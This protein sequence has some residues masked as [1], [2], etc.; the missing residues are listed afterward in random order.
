MRKVSHLAPA[1]FFTIWLAGVGS[2]WA[3]P[4]GDSAWVRTTLAAPSFVRGLLIQDAGKLYAWVYAADHFKLHSSSDNGVNWTA[5]GPSLSADHDATGL[6][7]RGS[8]FFLAARLGGVL[9][10]AEGDTAWVPVNSGFPADKDVYSI[11]VSGGVL[12]AGTNHSIF[13]SRDN[14]AKWFPISEGIPD[15]TIIPN[16]CVVGTTLFLATNRGDSFRGTPKDSGYAW[17]KEIMRFP[18]AVVARGKYL[19]S[20]SL[21]IP[22]GVSSPSRVNRS[23]DDGITWTASQSGIPSRG[24]AMALAAAGGSLFLGLNYFS[25]DSLSPIIFRSSDD[26]LS[27]QPA[28]SGLPSGAFLKSL[29]AN[30]ENIFAATLSGGIWRLP[31]ASLSIRAPLRRRPRAHGGIGAVLYNF[32]AEGFVDFALYSASGRFVAPLTEGF[33]EGRVDGQAFPIR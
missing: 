33:A 1:C 17:T 18:H 32:P 7:V 29:V 6:A 9:R 28:V 30:G 19:F 22:N 26:G 5:V 4:A 15:T 27:W 25:T 8:N 14:G 3:R 10:A 23:E 2:G 31:A 24:T 21:G 16:I 13:A 12:L 11:A 20:A